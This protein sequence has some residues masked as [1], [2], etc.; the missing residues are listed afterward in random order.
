MDKN[1]VLTEEAIRT[2]CNALRSSRHHLKWQL[3]VSLPNGKVNPN[4]KEIIEHQLAEVEAALKV[5]EEL[6][7]IM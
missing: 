5:F 3:E 7:E 2:A 4:K 6:E 1:I